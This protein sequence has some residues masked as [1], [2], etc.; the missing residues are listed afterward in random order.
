NARGWASQSNQ[1]TAQI[2]ASASVGEQILDTTGQCTGQIREPVVHAARNEDGG[3]THWVIEHVTFN[4]RVKGLVYAAN[5]RAQGD[6][7]A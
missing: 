4:F 1:L 3:P 5:S 7:C 6:F 2:Q